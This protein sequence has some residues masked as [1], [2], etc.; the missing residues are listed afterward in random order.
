MHDIENMH[1]YVKY[2]IM[3][4]HMNT[5]HFDMNPPVFICSIYKICKIICNNMH[6]PET[7]CNNMQKIK[8]MKKIKNMHFKRRLTAAVSPLSRFE[9]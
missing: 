4:S 5:L 6:P 7:I 3:I 2:V 9:L 8:H 1:G